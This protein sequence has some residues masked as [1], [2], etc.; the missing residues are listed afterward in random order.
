MTAPE[1]VALHPANA[2]E[3]FAT[4]LS[5]LILGRDLTPQEWEQVQIKTA[6]WWGI[7]QLKR[8]LLASVASLN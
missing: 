3:D 1:I 2:A 6:Y 5:D 8:D 4:Y 7:A